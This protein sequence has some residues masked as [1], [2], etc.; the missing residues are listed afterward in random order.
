MGF[1]IKEM[2]LQRLLSSRKAISHYSI[3]REWLLGFIEAKKSFI[4]KDTKPSIFGITQL[5]TD[6]PLFYAIQ[7]YLGADSIKELTPVKMVEAVS[8]ILCEEKKI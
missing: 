4:G 3:S 6:L 8:F 1:R 5:S 7:K 2:Y